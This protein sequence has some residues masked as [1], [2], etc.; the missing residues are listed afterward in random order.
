MRFTSICCRFADAIILRQGGSAL[1]ANTF[2]KTQRSLIGTPVLAPQAVD[3][4]PPATARDSASPQ[5]RPIAS[6]FVTQTEVEESIGLSP[7]GLSDALERADWKKHGAALHLGRG[8]GSPR[9][10]LLGLLP[11]IHLARAGA[12]DEAEGLLTVVRSVAEPTWH[13]FIALLQRRV[14]SH[15]SLA[16]AIARG[17]TAAIA[18]DMG[19]GPDLLRCAEELAV[20]QLE[21]IGD[22]PSIRVGV[23][24]KVA[25]DDANAVPLPNEL[26]SGRTGEEGAVIAV[27][28][29]GLVRLLYRVAMP[30]RATPLEP[31]TRIRADEPDVPGIGTGVRRVRSLKSR[32]R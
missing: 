17:D 3:I 16:W 27:A 20:R 12:T 10:Y 15:P 7:N 9:I 25:I 32:T 14:A 26:Q 18:R 22:S 13:E 11:A 4:P 5:R 1:A 19:I 6:P 30:A 31:G 28:T 23:W 8:R 29:S 24:R 21:V 2:P